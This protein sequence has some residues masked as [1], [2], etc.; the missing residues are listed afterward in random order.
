MNKWIQTFMCLLFGIGF[1]IF[2]ILVYNDYLS[3]LPPYASFTKVFFYFTVTF[4]LICF[5]AIFILMS[6]LIGGDGL[7]WKL[8][9]YMEDE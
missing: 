9:I 5:G 3:P 8:P 2:G 7:L 6:I 4:F 1:I